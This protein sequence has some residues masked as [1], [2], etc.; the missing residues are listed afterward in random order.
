MAPPTMTA[1]VTGHRSILSRVYNGVTRY[2]FGHGANIGQIAT[3]V[4]S[5]IEV[6]VKVNTVAQNVRRAEM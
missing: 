1:Y 2:E 5:E 6:L 3:P 4:I